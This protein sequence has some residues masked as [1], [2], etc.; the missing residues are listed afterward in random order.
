M[1]RLIFCCC[2]VAI[3]GL[4]GCGESTKTVKGTVTFAGEPVPEGE[5][6]LRPT[7]AKENPTTA[8]IK[9]GQFEAK[10]T[11]G[12]KRV[13]ITAFR[14]TGKKDPLDGAERKQYIPDRYNT[15]SQLTTEIKSDTAPLQ[16]KLVP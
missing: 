12:P 2:V 6:I 11:L 1:R 16:F 10:T 15:T 8:P 13:E 3:L 5:I 14:E 7:D 4:A 9:K